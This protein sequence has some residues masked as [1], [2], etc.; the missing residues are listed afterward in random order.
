MAK[1]FKFRKGDKVLVVMR[2]PNYGYYWSH[3]MTKMVNDGK[4]YRVESV[5]GPDQFTVNDWQFPAEA[6]KLASDNIMENIVTSDNIAHILTKVDKELIAALD[7]WP[8]FNSAHEGFAVLK[9]EVDELWDQ[10]KVNQKKR[11]LSKMRNEAIQV[12]AMAIRFAAEVANETQIMPGISE[13]AREEEEKMDNTKEELELMP[14]GSP[15]SGMVNPFKKENFYKEEK[16]DNNWKDTNPKDAVGIRKIPLST[17]PA[18]VLAEVGIAMLEGARKYG[19]HNYRVASV[20][21]SVYYDAAFRHLTDW[22]EGDDIDADSGISHLSKAIAGLIVI[23]DSMIQDKFI[24][25][26][27]PASPKG[28]QKKLQ[29]VIDGIFERHPTAVDAY[30]QKDLNN[31]EKA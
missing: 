16:H 25:D 28:W 2:I 21:A 15:L 26:R 14:P 6:L 5:E 12:A 17:I 18:P 20:R 22:W 31:G 7:N 1:K 4:I 3:S 9:E 10:V 23:R 29:S 27:P 8:P 30:T 13:L 11:D 19:R 24:D